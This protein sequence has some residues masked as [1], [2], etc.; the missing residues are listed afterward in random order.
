MEL[1]L[2]FL[3]CLL[4]STCGSPLLRLF[5]DSVVDGK[6]GK[7]KQGATRPWEGIDGQKSLGLN[8]EVLWSAT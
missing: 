1:T 5:V 4:V 3:I 6:Q 2:H 7:A 8:Q